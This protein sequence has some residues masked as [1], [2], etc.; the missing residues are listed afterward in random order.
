MKISFAIK[1]TILLLCIQET[2]S[3]DFYQL[4]GI[5]KDANNREI[6]KAFK[7]LALKYHPDKNSEED[8]H[9]K[10]LKINRAY[11]VKQL[12]NY[13]CFSPTYL[14]HSVLI[15]GFKRWGFEKKVWP[16]WRR[17]CWLPQEPETELSVLELLQWRFRDLRWWQGDRDPGLRGLQAQRPREFRHLVHKLLLPKVQPLPWPGAHLEKVKKDN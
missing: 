13:R 2:L 6:R 10:F 5:N 7:K 16:L 15:L 9:E 8:A 12:I 4:L 11:E 3:E 1:L 17:W 14:I